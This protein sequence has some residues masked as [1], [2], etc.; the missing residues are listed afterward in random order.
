MLIILE[1]TNKSGKTTLA[2]YIQEKFKDKNWKYIKCSQPKIVD[3]ENQ[4]FN[5]Y[6]S[7]IDSLKD[8]ENY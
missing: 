4:A 5:E 2:N 7:I 1:G 8:D 6:N 3:G